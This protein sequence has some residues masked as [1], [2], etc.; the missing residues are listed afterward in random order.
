MFS[1][2]LVPKQVKANG[3]AL[4]Y[5]YFCCI[6]GPPLLLLKQPW[7]PF[8]VEDGGPASSSMFLLLLKHQI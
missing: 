8:D 1:D 6:I 3:Q 7:V 2:Y 4:H 5:V